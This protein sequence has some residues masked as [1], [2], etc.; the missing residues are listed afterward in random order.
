MKYNFIL[1]EFNMVDFHQLVI[2]PLAVSVLFSIGC[3]FMT[4]VSIDVV[5]PHFISKGL[6]GKDLLKPKTPMMYIISDL[7]LKQWV[8][9]SE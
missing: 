7:A 5:T 2:H 6:C 1:F 8:L 3:Y 9:L 4:A